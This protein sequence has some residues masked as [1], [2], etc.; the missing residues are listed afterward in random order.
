MQDESILARRAFLKTS[1][2]VATAAIGA[3]VLPSLVSAATVADGADPRGFRA[4]FSPLTLARPGV[5]RP[6]LLRQALTA[7]DRLGTAIPRR[8]RIA[9]ADF[10][11]PSAQ[12]RFYLVD[13]AGGTPQALRVA[14][15]SGSDPDHSGWLHRFSNTPG[16][17]ASSEG[18]F[19][20]ADYYVGKHGLSQR[21]IGL[22]PSNN[23]ALERAL[24]I[25]SAWYANPEM[26][27][28]HEQLGRSQGCFAVGER[29]LAQVFD[30]LGPGR[31]VY[32]AKI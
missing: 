5:L 7:L 10:D 26:L 15:G 30:R 8:D 4:A 1:A 6:A 24:V 27:A 13:L 19:L 11:A 29:D 12:P 20:T 28:L 3:T 32:S 14:H 23:N 2:R 22:E 18:A 16:S 25:H 9:I 21:L 17:N 31:M